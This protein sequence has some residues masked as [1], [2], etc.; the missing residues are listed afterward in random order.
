MIARSSDTIGNLAAAIVAAAA[1]LEDV[2][3][4]GSASIPTK[5][6]GSYSYKYATLPGILQA[7]RPILQ[8]HGLA[9]LQNAHEGHNGSVDI[10]TMLVH[11][12]GEYL[13]LEALPMP[14]GNTA[15][16]TGSAI[17]YGRRYQLLAA[18]GLAADDDDDGATAAPRQTYTQSSSQRTNTGPRRPVSDKQRETLTRMYRERNM[19]IPDFDSMSSA[20]ASALF[21]ELKAIKPRPKGDELTRTENQEL[22]LA[23]AHDMLM[24]DEEPF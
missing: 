4:E 11:S 9:V 21:D 3:R 6:G 16:E 18:L 23:A 15:Q 19:P 20:D 5:S 24:G 2:K 13:V 10:S 17:T 12:S 14:L 1:E 8:K 22:E 7:V